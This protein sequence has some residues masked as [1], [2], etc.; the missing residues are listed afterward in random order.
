M[1]RILASLA[2]A[3]A[4][5]LAAVAPAAAQLTVQRSP[6][7]AP[8][9]GTTIRGSS[10]TVFSISPTGGV[11]RISGDA[12]RLTNASVRTPTITV[13]CGPNP[14]DSACAIRYIRVIITPAPGRGPASITRLRVGPL[15]GS[16]YTSGSTPAEGSTLDF[17]ISP[18]GL[19][20]DASFELGMDVRLAGGA[21]GGEHVFDY[22]VQ[23]QYL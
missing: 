22:V 16:R 11:S 13:S 20:R 2:L 15:Q 7:Q 4:F 6:A 8:T 5:S 12:I 1:K 3:V 9:L 19:F 17:V 18:L 10:P 14:F 23:V 21:P